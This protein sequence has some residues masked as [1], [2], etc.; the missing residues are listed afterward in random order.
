M[1]LKEH[2]MNTTQ[3]QKSATVRVD[4]INNEYES[5]SFKKLT[6]SVKAQRGA[7]KIIL[8]SISGHIPRGDMTALMVCS[9]NM[10]SIKISFIIYSF[11]L[12]TGP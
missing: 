12:I 10:H 8:N 3:S 11:E 6:Y 5:I 1:N 9:V 7:R 2:A 4:R